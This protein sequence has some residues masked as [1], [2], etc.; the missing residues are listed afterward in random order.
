MSRGIGKLQRAIL[1]RIESR[2][3]G[4]VIEDYTSYRM[5]LAPGIHDARQISHEMAREMGGISHRHFHS[6]KWDASFSR[7]LRGLEQ[8]GHVEVLRSLVPV[9]EVERD[10]KGSGQHLELS[11]GSYWSVRGRQRRFIRKPQKT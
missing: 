6:G 1:A 4:D 8:R 7:A 10:Y 3:G 5:R 9:A 11:D 2:L